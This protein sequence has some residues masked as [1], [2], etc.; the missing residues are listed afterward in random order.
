MVIENW[1]YAYR[2]D[3]GAAY[4]YSNVLESY[5][6]GENADLDFFWERV[7]SK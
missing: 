7:E 2:M 3:P 5:S 4:E 1:T 6:C